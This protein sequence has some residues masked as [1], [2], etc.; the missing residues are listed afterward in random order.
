ME[1]A[2]VD[3]AAAPRA[4]SSP[5]EGS[6]PFD[7]PP[8][9]L[10]AADV[11]DMATSLGE[12]LKLL[13][14]SRGYETPGDCGASNGGGGGCGG[15]GDCAQVAAPLAWR[16]VRALEA[17]EAHVAHARS[18]SRE[19]H[20]LR[21][22]LERAA[23][24]RERR[25]LR[26]REHLQYL[27][28]AEE[29]WR[30]ESCDLR[31]KLATSERERGRLERA[32]VL[33][34]AP[35]EDLSDDTWDLEDMIRLQNERDAAERKLKE[36]ER[37]LRERE[38][39]LKQKEQELRETEREMALSQRET[40]ALQLQ[41]SRL[42]CM[43]SELRR[44]KSCQAPPAAELEARKKSFPDSSVLRSEEKTGLQQKQTSVETPQKVTAPAT[45]AALKA[46]QNSDRNPPMEPNQQPKVDTES[47]A[48][49]HRKSNPPQNSGENREG[50]RYTVRELRHV[51]EERNQ[52][53]AE[54]LSLQ[55]ELALYRSDE[56]E[57]DVD[58]ANS[59]PAEKAPAV[60][61]DVSSSLFQTHQQSEPRIKRLIFTAIMPLVAAG[62]LYDDPTLQPIRNFVCDV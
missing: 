27:E 52:L 26:D 55:E 46:P 13:V 16:V 19:A 58:L 33:S 39:D 1:A 57:E 48:S 41:V 44:Q 45:Q 61:Q 14:S 42:V 62:L 7:K 35:V 59:L 30:Q 9:E 34:Q 4:W 29:L 56:G 21:R 12:A 18:A 6:S 15:P 11:W 40:K 3:G 53:K 54:L 28:Q 5:P 36:R 32:L 60:T 24:E 43:N 20:A 2:A 10:S 31:E 37:E 17:L 51:L 47:S 50:P 22:E 25:A 8:L 38:Q 23:G 49:E